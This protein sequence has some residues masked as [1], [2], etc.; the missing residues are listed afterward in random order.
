MSSDLRVTA[1]Q[2]SVQRRELLAGLQHQNTHRIGKPAVFAQLGKRSQEPIGRASDD[3][4]VFGEQS[5]HP[6]QQRRAFFLPAL[7]RTVPR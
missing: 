3:D 6:V 2:A 7:A 5:S 1:S 4:P